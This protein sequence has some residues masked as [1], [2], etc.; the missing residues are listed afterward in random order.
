MGGREREEIGREK[1]LGEEKRMGKIRYG[2]RQEGY[3][4]IQEN[5]SKYE[6]VEEKN[7]LKIPE[8]WDV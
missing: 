3:P 8:T 6:A 5:E 2:E 1:G 7:L 4:E